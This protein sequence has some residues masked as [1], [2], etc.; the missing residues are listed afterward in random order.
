MSV[1]MLTC[2]KP[3]GEEA[4]LSSSVAGDLGRHIPTSGHSQC[5]ER[6]RT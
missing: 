1:K 6:I 5:V 2:K 4:L 3:Q